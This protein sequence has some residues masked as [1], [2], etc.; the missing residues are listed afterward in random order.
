MSSTLITALRDRWEIEQELKAI[1]D[2]RSQQSLSS[3]AQQVAM[4]GDQVVPAILAQ[5]G[6]PDARMLNVLGAV[7]SSYPQRQQILNKLYEAA[8]DPERTDRERVSAMMI[9]E[10]FLGQAPDPYLVA[11]LN[12]PQAMAAES[13]KEMLREAERNPRAL[14]DYA[15]ALAEQ[16][17]EAIAGVVATLLEVGEE[18]AVPVLCLWAQDETET[19][20]EAALNALGRLRH[21]DAARGLQSILPLLP[22]ERRV[23]AERSLR[24]LRFSQVAVPALSPVDGTWRALVSPVDGAG[25]RV[26]WFVQDPD[27][28]GRCSF[29]GLSFSDSQGVRQAYGHHSVPASALPERQRVGHVHHVAIG[30]GMPGGRPA[31]PEGA[32]LYML[33]AGFDYGRQLVYEAHAVNRAVGQPLPAEY[34][35]LGPVLWQYEFEEVR[36]QLPPAPIISTDLM[37]ETVHLLQHPAFRGWAVHGEQV[38]RYAATRFARGEQGGSHP[39]F[40]HLAAAY[41]DQ[42]EIERLRARLEAMGEWLWRA[43]EARWAGLAL[44]AAATVVRTSPAVHPL[45]RGMVELGLNQVVHQLQRSISSRGVLTPADGL[46]P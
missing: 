32:S 5:L 2:V 16:P 7:A 18:R 39:A 24:K 42:G 10:R 44:V 8:A 28:W 9:M 23:L 15:R 40:E 43:G 22:A 20:A 46:G 25:G 21:A 41:F 17:E 14:V 3:R 35:L 1:L 11:T 45:T 33:E 38:V 29:I 31:V 36:R 12:D 4:R 6:C 26:V 34:R 13:I 37:R 30:R 27:A 19:L